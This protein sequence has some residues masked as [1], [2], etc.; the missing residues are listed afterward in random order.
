[1]AEAV[2]VLLEA[3]EVQQHQQ[4]ALAVNESALGA[5]EIAD[6][7]PAIAETGE[8]VRARLLAARSQH[9]Q[10][11][12]EGERQPHQDGAQTGRRQGQREQVDA[13]EVVIERDDHG[14]GRREDRHDDIR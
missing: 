14:D 2:V 4:H 5:L 12:G 1:M 10:I 13:M 6:E 9:P 7:R 3:V 11:P 8:D